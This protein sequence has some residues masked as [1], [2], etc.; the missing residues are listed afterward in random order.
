M[1]SQRCQQ[2]II[3]LITREESEN[4]YS[5]KQWL[6]KNKFLT[7][8]ATDV[9][10]VIEEI[11]DFTVRR[12]PDVILLEV[13][14]DEHESV[15]EMFHVSSGTTEIQIVAFSKTTGGKNQKL[16]SVSQLKAKF[17]EVLPPLS[18]AA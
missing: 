16:A 2:P 3:L 8:E 10:Q 18:R 1:A 17:N 14:A 13:E 12:C 6:R 9:F 7:R 4:C 15:T 5:L 11:N